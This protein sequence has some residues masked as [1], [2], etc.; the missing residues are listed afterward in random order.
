MLK[1]LQTTVLKYSLRRLGIKLSQGV[2]GFQKNATL[3]LEEH[4]SIN[5]CATEFDHLDV[6]AYTFI[7]KGG[8]LLNIAAIGRYCSISTDVVLGQNAKS[9]PIE[10]VSTHQFKTNALR[11][12]SEKTS[13]TVVGHDVW[14]GR[15]AMIMNGVTIGTGAIIGARAIVTHDIPPYAIAIGAPA[16]IV[17]YRHSPEIIAR[18]LASLWW[19]VDSEVLKHLPFD[20]PANFLEEIGAVSRPAKYRKISVARNTWRISC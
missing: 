1:K 5:A 7:R 14:I 4:V 13:Q 3:V 10:W 2:S 11:K 19:E 17:N 6:G 16:R 18:L 8:E 20:D 15:G 12:D 9:H